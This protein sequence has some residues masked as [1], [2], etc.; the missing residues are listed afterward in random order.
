M[1]NILT[2]MDKEI[3]AYFSAPIAYLAFFIFLLISGMFYNYSV[4]EKHDSRMFNVFFLMI[5]LFILIIP[6]LTMHLFAEERRSGT[7]EL[8]M[9]YPI[10]DWEVVLGKFFAGFGIF[11]GMMVL[12]F[13]FPLFLFMWGNSDPGVIFTGYLG[14]ILLGATFLS[15]GMLATS[16]TQSQNVAYIVAAGILFVLLMILGKI[17][18]SMVGQGSFADFIAYI[19]FSEH[20]RSF[21]M[22]IIN[23]RDVIFYLSVIFFALFTSIRIVEIK[24]WKG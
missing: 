21:A 6:A 13:H 1:K 24:R 16:F 8:L 18:D 9:T 4:I 19:S 12:T 17:G 7:I 10:Q 11:I 23:S 5:Y 14:L 22:G 3:R 15:I 2:I 20:F